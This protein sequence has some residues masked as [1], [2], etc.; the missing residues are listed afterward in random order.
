MP[1]AGRCGLGVGG[2][3]GKSFLNVYPFLAPSQLQ[4]WGTGQRGLNGNTGLN[5]LS[6]PRYFMQAPSL[7]LPAELG[8]RAS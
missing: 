4:G 1:M 2:K 6:Q 3:P 7:S 5:P 8:A